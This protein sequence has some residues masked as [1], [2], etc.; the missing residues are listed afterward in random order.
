MLGIPVYRSPHFGNVAKRLS[1][2]CDYSGLESYIRINGDSPFLD[3]SLL[4]HGMQAYFSDQ[5]DLVT[6]LFPRSYPCGINSEIIGN[7]VL[8]SY[9]KNLTNQESEH[10]TAWFYSHPERL[11]RH[12][13]RSEFR[14]NT[15]VRMT[16]D[17]IEDH[18]RIEDDLR[19]TTYG[20]YLMNHNIN[21]EYFI[22]NSDLNQSFK[23]RPT[24]L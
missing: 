21:Y 6:N 23:S 18:Q 3:S 13:I 20:N 16:P 10:V 17:I 12:N 22:K 24:H 14:Y 7:S 4:T 15:S 11:V 5:I 8:K 2:A 9:I 1:A 19:H